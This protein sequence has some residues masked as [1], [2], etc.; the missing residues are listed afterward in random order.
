MSVKYSS[1]IFSVKKIATNHRISFY[2]VAESKQYLKIIIS[3]QRME[4]FDQWDTLSHEAKSIFF[5]LDTTVIS[6]KLN[7]A[8]EFLCIGAITTI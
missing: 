7:K 3:V 6:I 4:N 8:G 2:K 1:K 5:Y